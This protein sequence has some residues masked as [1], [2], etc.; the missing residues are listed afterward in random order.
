M[1]SPP[2]PFWF[3]KS[4]LWIINFLI[5]L[6][7]GHPLKWRGF[8]VV[9]PMSFS[10]VHNAQKFSAVLGTI[11]KTNSTNSLPSDVHVEED[12]RVTGVG[13]LSLG[14]WMRHCSLR[15][16]VRPP[17]DTAWSP[18]GSNPKVTHYFIFYGK[19]SNWCTATHWR[20]RKDIEPSAFLQLWGAWESC[21]LRT[22]H[23]LWAAF[24]GLQ[25]CC[26]QENND[27]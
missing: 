5:I 3:E 23:Q 25:S 2:V 17:R 22:S 1:L 27:P 20:A 18:W 7:K 9:G 11:S 10:P 6:W 8:P 16:R 13:G 21:N 14:G 24:G 19:V 15:T 12:S 26:G 4:P